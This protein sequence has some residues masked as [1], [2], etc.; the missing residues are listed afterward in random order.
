[1]RHQLLRTIFLM[2]F[3]LLLFTSCHFQMP[4]SPT[5]SVVV[6]EVIVQ[7]VP[8][9]FYTTGE[10][11]AVK[12]VDIIAR[13][14]GT[15]EKMF[16]KKGEVVPEGKPLFLI[17]QAS[18]TIAIQSAQ[19]KLDSARA[20]LGLAES[21]LEKTR[22]LVKRNAATDQ[23]MQ[24]DVSAR[25][26]A[27][28]AVQDAEA[29]LAQAELNLKYTEIISPITGK[30]NTSEVAAGNL[31]GPGTNNTVLTTIVS[32]DPMGVIFSVTDVDFHRL[33]EEYN[34]KKENNKERTEAQQFEM[35]FF[36]S[37]DPPLENYP[38]KGII[39][40]TGNNI[41]QST[42]TLIFYGEIP[43]P[44]Y[45]MLPG[46]VCRIRILEKIQENAVLI[47]QEAVSIDLNHHYVFV[48]DEKNTAHRRNIE[49]GDIQPDNTRIVLKGLE[50][51][52]RYVVRGVQHVRDD[53]E[54]KVVSK[55]EQ[56]KEDTAAQ[57]KNDSSVPQQ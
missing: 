46:E 37:S 56:K 55:E 29:A 24:T 22:Q 47:R 13:V 14:T 57:I 43:N 49:L 38:F 28:A 33:V 8:K 36:K 16:Y 6:E 10:T 34:Q 12:S 52:E 18:Y 53:A 19:A 39:K 17:E 35:G 40:A 41:N 42:G 3:S 9:Y 30:T 27:A 5:P 23:D 20:K 45:E 31:V 51:G 54:V 32:I 25:D 15:L 21:T 4:Q 50:K 44:R 11:T 2:S 48:V 26:Q 1:M 7:D